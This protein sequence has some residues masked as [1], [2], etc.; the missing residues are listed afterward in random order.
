MIVRVNGYEIENIP[1]YSSGC[2][3]LHLYTDETYD[4]IYSKYHT[5]I[6][7]QLSEDDNKTAVRRYI[8][9]DITSMRVIGLTPREIEVSLDVASVGD[10]ALDQLTEQANDTEDAVG[11]ALVSIR[12]LESKLRTIE[13]RMKT[14]E[15]KLYSIDDEIAHLGDVDESEAVTNE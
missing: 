14:F 10:E 3:I 8:I 12:A 15:D 4:Q 5:G 7:E 11:F 1:V 9:H 2:V 6:F 13:T